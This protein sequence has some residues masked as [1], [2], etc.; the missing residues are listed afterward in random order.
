MAK[1]LSVA[2][3]FERSAA[4][5]DLM[6]DLMSLGAHRL[7]KRVLV[8][9]I[10]KG[11]VHQSAAH[12]LA[13]IAGGSGDIGLAALRANTLLEVFSCDE[14]AQMLAQAQTRLN[15][16]SENIR[17]RFHLVRLNGEALPLASDSMDCC[18]ISFGIRNI[19]ARSAALSEMFR[20]LKYGGKFL[21]LEFNSQIEPSLQ[22]LYE[23]YS[24][25]CIPFLAQS[26][27]G[28]RAPYDYLIQSIKEFPAPET[29]A[30]MLSAAGFSKIKLTPL[31]AGVVT[32]YSAYKI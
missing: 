16:E 25:R 30:Q 23:F 28:D 3:V 9:K 29:F 11:A 12:R 18:T 13:D 20:V 24:N 19:K 22:G 1:F 15:K 2:E 17:Q 32:I 31:S 21:C 27:M 6:N 14:N 4:R 26:I 5:Y 8:D 7:W 10:P